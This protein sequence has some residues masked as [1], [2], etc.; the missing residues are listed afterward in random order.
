MSFSGAVERARSLLRGRH[1][2]SIVTLVLVAGIA[3]SISVFAVE[4]LTPLI[5]ADNFIKDVEFAFAA[6]DQP[7]DDRVRIVAIDEDTLHHLP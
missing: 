5:N 6:H 1:F 3:A 4:H 2:S 7:S